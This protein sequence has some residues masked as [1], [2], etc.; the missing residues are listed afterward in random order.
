MKTAT[1]RFE[2]ESFWFPLR[3]TP[4]ADAL[5]ASARVRS[6][7]EA[8]TQGTGRDA[9]L[10]M[11]LHEAFEAADRADWDGYGAKPMD[12]T[13]R[14]HAT[15]FLNELP[16]A[17]PLPDVCATPEGFVELDWW[18]PGDQIVSVVIDGRGKLTFSSILSGTRLSG[19]AMLYDEI[20]PIF[21][22]ELQRV[23][24]PR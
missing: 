7:P 10:A 15:E 9:Q 21:F 3:A 5:R 6:H 24:H 1:L 2:Q 12:M 14:L 11:A 13:A 8:R 19:S 18:G 17:T 4:T 16:T 22:S 20:A 23:L